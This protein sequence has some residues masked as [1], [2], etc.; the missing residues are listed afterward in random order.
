MSNP[1]CA[2]PALFLEVGRSRQRALTW[3]F[4]CGVC[5]IAIVVLMERGS[6][7]SVLLLLLPLIIALGRLRRDPM[8]GVRLCQRS[9]SW[10]LG[11]A[12]EEW[13]VEV[14]GATLLAGRV[15]YLDVRH[16]PPVVCKFLWIHA[17]SVGC[18]DFRRLCRDLA[19][20]V[21]VAH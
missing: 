16:G 10:Y 20:R 9:G 5:G 21:P 4:F 17:D 15:V 18:A 19:L 2:S 3:L 12:G 11:I 6:H 13:P 8:Q 14:R 7:G 1:S